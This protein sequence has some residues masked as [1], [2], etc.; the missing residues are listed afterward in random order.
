MSS[1]QRIEE[2]APETVEAWAD[3]SKWDRLIKAPRRPDRPD[4]A[5]YRPPLPDD[6]R[7]FPAQ[8]FRR[9]IFGLVIELSRAGAGWRFLAKSA[10]SG[11]KVMEQPDAAAAE[12]PTPQSAARAAFTALAEELERRRPRFV[13]AR[14]AGQ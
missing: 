2:P 7:G 5:W 12:Q 3:L 8:R 1:E 13:A 9:I 14:A 4:L 11:A 6:L 10:W